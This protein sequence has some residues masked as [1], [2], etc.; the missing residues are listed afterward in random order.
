MKPSITAFYNFTKSGVVMADK[1]CVSF[2]ASRNTRRWF[3]VVFFAMLSIAGIN[4]QII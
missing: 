2:S 3:I 4:A 1:M